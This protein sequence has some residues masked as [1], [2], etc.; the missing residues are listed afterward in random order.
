[1]RTAERAKT[2]F[3]ETGLNITRIGFRGSE[4]IAGGALQGLD[5][6]LQVLADRYQTTAGAVAVALTLVN[7]AV[8]GAIVRFRR[9]DRVDPLGAAASLKRS[10]DDLA[11]IGAA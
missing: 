6:R 1:M 11:L 5:E 7:P 2:Q 10:A 8:D 9:P 3:G 4:E